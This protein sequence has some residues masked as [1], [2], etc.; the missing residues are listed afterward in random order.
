MLLYRRFGCE[1]V[2]PKTI[3]FGRW[4]Q[5]VSRVKP[6][7]IPIK[8]VVGAWVVEIGI[9]NALVRGQFSKLRA[10]L[11]RSPTVDPVNR[12]Q[13]RRHRTYVAS[14][15]H[16]Y[17][18]GFYFRRAQQVRRRIA[19]P[20]QVGKPQN[21]VAARLDQNHVERLVRC[22]MQLLRKRTMRYRLEPVAGI[23]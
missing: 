11:S 12:Y 19:Q 7:R 14:A 10:D 1:L 23:C 17:V 2:E 15:H 8:R 6:V 9:V 22:S 13:K 16:D 18:S 4:M 21:I 5:S 3:A 20:I